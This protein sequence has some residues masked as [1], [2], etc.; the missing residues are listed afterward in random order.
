MY[1][2]FVD[3]FFSE[4]NKHRNTSSRLYARRKALNTV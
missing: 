4:E 3:F 1:V 2:Y